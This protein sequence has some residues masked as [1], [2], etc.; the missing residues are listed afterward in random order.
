MKYALVNQTVASI[1]KTGF[2]ESERT[3]EALYGMRIE[4]ISKTGNWC[5]ISTRYGYSGYMHEDC[6]ISDEKQIRRFDDSGK[7]TVIKAYADV[8]AAPDIKSSIILSLVRGSVVAERGDYEN[9]FMKIML[10]DGRAG[11]IKAGFLS[12][13]IYPV[14]YIKSGIDEKRL[15][16][17]I[18]NTA[19]SYMGTQYRWGGKSPL[20][21]DCSGLCSMA[22]MLNGI[23]IYRDA[24]IMDGYP[25]HEIEFQRLKP[26]DLVYFPGHM[27][28][29]LGNGKYVHSTNRQGSDGVV[30]NGFNKLDADF[31]EDLF[32]SILCAGSV[33]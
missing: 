22:Y 15:R 12:D 7:K 25:V 14:R 16:E 32:N 17:N 19:L 1:R 9:G 8:L 29:Y 18:I 13:S 26:A 21:I 31:R 23:I 33:F 30:I 5:E 24:K 20:G 2:P 4:I 6:L 27:A 11:Y 28:L 3:D 10:C